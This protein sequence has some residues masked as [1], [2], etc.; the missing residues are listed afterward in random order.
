MQT[1]TQKDAERH[2]L[3]YVLGFC[4]VVSL[5]LDMHQVHINDQQLSLF[6]LIILILLNDL[7]FTSLAL[8]SFCCSLRLGFCDV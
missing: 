8:S 3:S 2:K 7:V 6:K 5:H 4:H 1:H